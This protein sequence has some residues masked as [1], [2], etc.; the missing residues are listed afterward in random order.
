MGKRIVFCDV[1]GT[2]LTSDHRVL[3]KTLAAIRAL[4]RRGVPFVIASS[5]GPYAIE[6][7]LRRY[8]FR[9]AMI[10]FGG[11]LILD[12]RG[13][14]IAFSGFPPAL[15]RRVIACLAESGCD[16]VWNLYTRDRWLTKDRSDARVRFEESIVWGEAE[17]ADPDA[18]AEDTAVGKLLCM[19]RPQDTAAL[20]RR[21]R[22]AFP[23]LSV[24]R[25]TEAQIEIVRGGVAKGEAVRA[26]CAA[27]GIPT[28]DAVAFGDQE[29]DLGMLEAVGTP[30]LMGNAPEPLRR[31]IAN[32]T[33]SNDAEGIYNA[34][35][36][37]GMIDAL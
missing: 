27:W 4:G 17:Q 28:A 13:R 7:I 25:S 36:K 31:R 19:C 16:C 33:D 29:N 15:A 30:F 6:P 26:L 35:V 23:M 34:L 2:L 20:E 21:L 11:G 10:C 22:E 1:D 5:R 32:L 24:V 3:P 8:G 12:E 9:C 18:L 14:E 37:I